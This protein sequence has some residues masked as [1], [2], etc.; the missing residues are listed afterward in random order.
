[1]CYFNDTATTE[2]YTLSLHDALPISFLQ[3]G[4]TRELE[5]SFESF[6]AERGYRIAPVTIDTM[7][8]MFLSAYARARAQGDAGMVRRVSDEYL[9]YVGLKFDFCERVSTEL[10]GRQIRHI[11]LLHEIGRA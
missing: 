9:K 10:F 1:M 7:D 3:M 8:W 6:L 4:A 5:R 11:L 2:I